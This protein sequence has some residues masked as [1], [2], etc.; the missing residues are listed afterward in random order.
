MRR[1]LALTAAGLALTTASD[2][3]AGPPYVTDDPEPTELAG[4]EVYG[5]AA[6]TSFSHALEGEAGLD[7]N[8][9]AAKDLQASATLSFG[10]EQEGGARIH[11]NIADTEVGLKYRFLHQSDGT[12]MPDVALF[13]KVTLPTA[14]H[15]DGSGKVGFQ[16]PVWAQKDF[17]GWSLFGG[18]GFQINPGAG[19][20]DFV[21]EGI[22]LTR[23]VSNALSLGGE[24]YHQSA[25][26]RAGRSTSGLGLG[27]SWR[28]APH[29]AVIGSGGPLLSHRSTSGRYAFYVALAFAR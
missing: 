28:V 25:D 19:N 7:L 5:F 3:D 11:T 24:V 29:W 9:G 6:G 4:W 26:S 12:L 8:Y 14:G 10:Y 16:L 20:R 1:A 21:F 13:P 27:A 22:A 18:G 17:R 23:Q 2:A 15:H